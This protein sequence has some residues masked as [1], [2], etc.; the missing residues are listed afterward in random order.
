MKRIRLAQ[1][2]I[3]FQRDDTGSQ[4][5]AILYKMIEKIRIQPNYIL[6]KSPEDTELTIFIEKRFG[7][8]TQF[9]YGTDPNHTD[10]NE[11][12]AA[13]LAMRMTPY[14]IFDNEFLHGR[15]IYNLERKKTNDLINLKG[16]VDLKKAKVSGIFSKNPL[17]VYFHLKTLKHLVGLSVPEMTGILLHELGH[18]F[19]Y[20]EFSS[21]LSSNNQ[22]LQ[23][24]ADAFR[25]NNKKELQYIFK[26]IT[27][28]NDIDQKSFDDLVDEENRVIFGLK[29]FQRYISILVSGLPNAKYNETASEQLADNFAARFGYGKEVIT[30]LD[31]LFKGAPEKS[32]FGRAMFVMFELISIMVAILGPFVGIMVVAEA[33]IILVYSLLFLFMMP[34]ILY[35]S[36]DNFVD[37]TYDRLK[38]RYM[39]IRHQ[40]I[41][42]LKLGNISKQD[43]AK[44]IEDIKTM[45]EIINKTVIFRGL[46]SNVSNWLFTINK[47][48]KRDIEFQQ[49][50]EQLA[51]N[52]LFL[53]SAELSTL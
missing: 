18:A 24:L 45:D 9:S 1:E 23:N 36:G 35:M 50:L 14:H 22:V 11:P 8:Q 33:P 7:I 52:D 34:T 20:F 51:H 6:E 26:E 4:I 53:K 43:L 12:I 10:I 49:L 44:T 29:F 41:E 3:D 42:A 27:I 37:M 16:T 46:F 47:N 38:I 32:G 30:G 39:R 40:Y 5:E 17:N 21:R 2:V 31:K 48:T 19:T 15:E 25:T 28:N 13:C